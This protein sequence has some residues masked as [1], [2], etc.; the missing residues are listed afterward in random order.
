MDFITNLPPSS[1]YDSI[2]VEVDRLMKIIHFILCTKTI[3]S[4]RTTKLILDHVFWYHGLFEGI[5]FDRGP[6][7]ASKS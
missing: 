7:F 6:Q 2:L 4:E 1:S 5:I 3:T